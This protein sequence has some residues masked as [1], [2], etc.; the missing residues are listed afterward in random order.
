[1]G[2]DNMR[3]TEAKTGFIDVGRGTPWRLRTVG[4]KAE[5]AAGTLNLLV[6]HG[7]DLRKLNCRESPCADL[8]LQ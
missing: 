3:R 5:E 4:E 1:M 8:N 7:K 2:T 6:G